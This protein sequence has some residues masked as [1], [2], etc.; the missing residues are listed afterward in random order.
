M[1]CL[2]KQV[3]NAAAR[4]AAHA[5]AGILSVVL[6]LET[7]LAGKDAILQRFKGVVHQYSSRIRLAII[8][9]VTSNPTCHMPLEQLAAMF[10]ANGIRGDFQDKSPRGR[11][12]CTLS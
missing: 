6:D 9:H 12:D 8:D 5:G 4:F 1:L 7:L 3:V 11:G 10:R 2:T